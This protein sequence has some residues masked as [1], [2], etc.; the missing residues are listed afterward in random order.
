MFAVNTIKQ[1]L[2]LPVETHVTAQLGA[3]SPALALFRDFRD[4]APVIIESTGLVVD[5]VDP[6]G[7]SPYEFGLVVSPQSEVV[8]YLPEDRL[9]QERRMILQ[10]EGFDLTQLDASQLMK[11]ITTMLSLDLAALTRVSVRKLARLMLSNDL[12]ELVVI[13]GAT[14]ELRAIITQT[15]MRRLLLVPT[16]RPSGLSEIVA[17][18]HA[19]A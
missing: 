9:S 12:E 13:D 4:I 11:P 1:G 10:A 19:S 15:Q 2:L 18:L 3:H 17:N 16:H 14:Q 8:G 5:A 6:L 7:R